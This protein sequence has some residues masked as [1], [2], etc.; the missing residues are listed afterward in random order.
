MGIQL[1]KE[2]TQAQGSLTAAFSGSSGASSKSTRKPRAEAAN[3]W[4]SATRVIH[5]CIASKMPIKGAVAAAKAAVA[6]LAKKKA[7]VAPPEVLEGLDA[8][9]RELY[10]AKSSKTK[11]AVK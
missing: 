10:A 9:V 6:K 11:A 5:N 7:S 8:R 3:Y 1:L 2:F 4:T